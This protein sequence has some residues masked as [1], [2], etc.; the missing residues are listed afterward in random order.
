MH[1]DIDCD[2]FH[3]APPVEDNEDRQVKEEREAEEKEAQSTTSA[4]PKAPVRSPTAT[5]SIASTSRVSGSKKT[6]I[7]EKSKPSSTT[8]T[9]GFSLGLVSATRS[10]TEQAV[11]LEQATQNSQD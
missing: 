3:P 9:I 8:H 6:R 1:R 7:L 10:R 11:K 2:T 4:R 5:E